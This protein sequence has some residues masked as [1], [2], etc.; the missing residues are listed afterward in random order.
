MVYFGEE[1]AALFPLLDDVFRTRPTAVWCELLAAAEL[2]FAP[3]RDHAEV[4]ADPAVWAN[5]YLTKAHGPDGEVDVVA[6]PVSFSDTPASAP[7]TA[8]ELGQHTEEI[9]L[10][11]GYDWEQIAALSAAGAT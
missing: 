7:A 11:L 5:G 4:V 8:P 10:E 9:L 6:A 2:R 1:K 3:V